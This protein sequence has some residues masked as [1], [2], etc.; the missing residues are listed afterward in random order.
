M[1][2]NITSFY[3]C[4]ADDINL[5]PWSLFTW[6]NVLLISIHKY[7]EVADILLSGRRR[8][9]RRKT[10]LNRFFLNTSKTFFITKTSKK[11][12]CPPPFIGRRILW[13]V[14]FF[15][16]HFQQLNLILITLLAFVFISTHIR[17][18]VIRIKRTRTTRP[19]VFN[20]ESWLKKV[21]DKKRY[22]NN[23]FCVY[24]FNDIAMEL[25]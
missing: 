15:F 7:Y 1:F 23:K 4:E 16:V 24:I 14:F 9:C 22:F 10:I 19:L 8:V 17:A 13:A 6:I 18:Y 20:L 25:P 21:F 3:L 12:D 11:S 5:L 2:K